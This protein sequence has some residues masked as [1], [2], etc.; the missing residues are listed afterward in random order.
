MLGIVFVFDHI[1]ASWLEL[2]LELHL[3]Q[4]VHDESVDLRVS[5][6]AAPFRTGDILGS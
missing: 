4:G 2:A 6:G 1:W 5:S 3:V